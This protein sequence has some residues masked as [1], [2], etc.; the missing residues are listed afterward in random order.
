MQATGIEEPMYR[1]WLAPA[2][3]LHSDREFWRR[4]S[5]GFAWFSARGFSS[6]YRL[7]VSFEENTTCAAHFRL[8]P[9][10]DVLGE[11]GGFYVLALSQ[12][13]VRLLHGNWQLRSGRGRVGERA[14]QPC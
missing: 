13:R 4:Q 6:F 8:I 5:D 11:T 12:K 14:G 2:W 7:P 10:L 9:M 3:Q 1:K